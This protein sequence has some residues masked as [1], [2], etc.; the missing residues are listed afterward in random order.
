MRALS[1]IFLINEIEE[2]ERQKRTLNKT[3]VMMITVGFKR[4]PSQIFWYVTFLMHLA[5]FWIAQL[6]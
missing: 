3:C 1:N 2:L 6:F 5:T 4:L